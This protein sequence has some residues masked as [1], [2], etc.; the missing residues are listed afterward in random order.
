M[1]RSLRWLALAALLG[2]AS[3]CGTTATPASPAVSASE[4]VQD[5]GS[6]Q[7]PEDTTPDGLPVGPDGPADDTPDGTP[8]DAPDDAPAEPAAED[9]ISYDP[10]NL[11]VVA[12]GATWTLRDGGHAIKVLA[13]KSDA[14]AARTVARLWTRLC[15]IGRGNDRTDRYRYIVTY[16]KSPSG[17][18]LQLAP[19]LDCISYDPTKLSVYFGSPHPADPDQ[20]DYALYSAGTP[21]L[22]LATEADALRA[23][24]VAAG[25][26]QVCVIGHGNALPNPARYY[27]HM[28]H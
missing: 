7:A 12:S 27:L 10:A 14:D 28:W 15:F 1:K 3:A 23:Q 22:F 9:C 24:L 20:N 5:A 11:T 16:W 2:T 6:D 19:A 4:V 18:P 21:L 13:T 8:E 25:H 17:L 26:T